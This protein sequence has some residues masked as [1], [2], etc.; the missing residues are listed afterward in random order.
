MGMSAALK[1]GTIVENVAKI[2]AIELLA[3]AQGVEFHRP[4]RSGARIEDAL[5]RLRRIAPGFR[6]DEEFSV[7]IETVAQA[8]LDGYFL[9]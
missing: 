9:V 2:T 1:L 6:G 7:R 4:L 8:I 5:A 3:A